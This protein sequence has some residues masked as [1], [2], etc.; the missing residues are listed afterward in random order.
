MK[1][2]ENEKAEKPT[3]TKK[4]KLPKKKKPSTNPPKFASKSTFGS[5]RAFKRW[6]QQTLFHQRHEHTLFLLL[7]N[8]SIRFFKMLKERLIFLKKER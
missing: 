5:S 7:Y 1:G 3:I 8:I 6:H 4:E 2:K